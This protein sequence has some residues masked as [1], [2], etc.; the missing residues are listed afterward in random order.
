MPQSISVT[1]ANA[2]GRFNVADA[3]C[4][5]SFGAVTATGAPTTLSPLDKAILFGTSN[6][7]PP[8]GSVAL[9]NNFANLEDR[10]STTDQDLRGAL[11][12]RS[13]A[14]GREATTHAALSPTQARQAQRIED[15]VEEI[16][17]TGRLHRTPT[18]IVTGRADDIL[19]PNFTSRG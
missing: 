11:C 3:L 10:R 5:Y 15:G 9:I 16:L 2:Y 8:T 17:A 1:Y 14:T 12:L 6:G 18:L 7:I 19:P 13:L 4:G